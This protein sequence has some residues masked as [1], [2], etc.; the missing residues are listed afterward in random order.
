MSRTKTE[1]T[2]RFL[3]GTN[4]LNI[5]GKVHGGAVMKWMDEAAYACA[6][7]W[8]GGPCVT[9]YVSGIRFVRPVLVGH[10]VEVSAQLIYTGRTSMHVML[11]VSSGT[12]QSRQLEEK[13]HSIIVFVA[14]DGDGN[15]TPVE[16]YKPQTPDELALEQYAIELMDVRKR[17]EEMVR[18]PG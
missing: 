16:K 11:K 10:L 3:A 9:I 12:P 6:A 13:T 7:A 4:D 2:L 8:C 18:L 17:I 14:L 1:V 5:Y 15:P